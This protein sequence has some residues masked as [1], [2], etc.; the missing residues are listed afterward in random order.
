MSSEN[1][2]N[3]Y[4]LIDLNDNTRVVQPTMNELRAIAR[5]RGLRGYTTLCKDD[6][7]KFIINPGEVQPTINELRT[8]AKKRGLRGYTALSKDEL[9]QLINARQRLLD[10]PVPVIGTPILHPTEPSRNTVIETVHTIKNKFNEWANW[11]MEHIP[12]KPKVDEVLDSLKNKVNNI[13]NKFYKKKFELRESKTALKGNTKQYTIDGTEGID[14]VS[15]LNTIRPQVTNLLSSNRQI[16]VYF[17]LTC[18]MEKVDIKSGEVVTTEPYFSSKA[19]VNLDATDVGELYTNAVDQIMERMANFQMRGSNWKFRSVVK[20]DINT[21]VYKPLKGKSYIPLP[22]ELASKK[23][24][25]NMKNDD[26]QCFKWCVTR[27]LNPVGR[28]SENIT[29]ILRKQA[30]NLNWKGIEF[31]VAVSENVISRFEKNND[32]SLNVF[33]YEKDVYPLHISKQQRDKIVDLLLISD[34]KNKHYCWIKNFNRLMSRQTEKS[35]NSMHYCR[36]CLNGFSTDNALNKH[37]EYCSQHDA[38]K[39]YLPEPGTKL[40]FTN[41]NRLMRVPFIVYADFESF[42]KPI[43]TCQ[44]NSSESYTNKYQK[45]TPSSFCYYIKCFNDSV[46][47]PKLVSFTAESENDDVAKIFVNSLEEDIKQIY[48]QFKFKKKMI[49]TK[50]D[51]KSFNAATICHICEKDFSK[52]D[53][54]VRDHCHLS[55]KFRGAAHNS[56][57][58]SYQ[59]PK[60]FPIVFHNLSGYDSHLF[61]KKLR[62]NNEEKINCIPNSEEKY[63]S[64]SREVIVDKYKKD[65]EEKTVRRELRFIDSFRFMPSSLEALSEN[66]HK[67]QCK[68][69]AKHYSDKQ[70][71]LL[72]RKGVYPYN[73]VDSIDRLSETELPPKEAFYSKLNDSDISDEDYRHAQTVWN[74]FGCR[75][76]RDYHNIYNKSDVLLLADIFENFRDVCLNNY[77]LDPAWYYTSPGLAWDAAL[78]LTDVELE[79]L[80]DYDMILMIKHGI[81]GGISTISNRYA[82]ANNKYMG[83]AFDSSKPSSFITYHDTNSLY[84][85][86]MSK[87]LPTHGFK[88]IDTVELD[89]WKNHSCILEVDLEYSVD[90]HDLHN[91]YPL[92]PESLKLEGSVV[93]KLIPNLKDKKKYIIHCENLQ[94]YESLGLKITKIHRG[95]TFEESAWLKKYI[96]LNTEL[97]TKATNDFEKD[98]FKLMSNSVFGKTMENIENRVDV[99]LVCHENEAIKLTAKPNYDRHTIFDENLIAVHMKRT[100]L[101]YNKP[102]YLGMCILDLSK[103]LMYD[104]HYNYIKKKYGDDAMLLFTDT[105]S[106]AY[107]IKTENFYKDINNDIESRFDTSGYPENHPSGIK[108]GINKKVIGMFKDEAGGK[109]I[110]EFVGL[111][112]KLYSY[113][114]F[115]GDEHKKCKGIK[116]NVVKKSITHEDYKD[117][118]FT[119]REHLRRMNVIRSHHHDIFTEEINKVALSA[120]D[121]KRVIMDDGIRTLAYGHYCMRS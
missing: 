83:E 2:M 39:I 120:D 115:E 116:K 68:N 104:F 15:F 11:L 46:Y 76:L 32:I 82:K 106:L 66:L 29:K 31:P 53:E 55:G 99:R 103:T 30:E 75:S 86:A 71:D 100:K 81:R 8:I 59:V 35:H 61:I 27:A 21:V 91:D 64:F 12:E 102:I 96:D 41:Y 121:D 13:F 98:F 74:K 45:H 49:F 62:G 56:C 110:E 26:D 90:L 23:A 3:V 94:L 85:W 1:K 17:V 84:A 69:L 60:F 95:I 114:M 16:K 47:P 7:I 118:L 113:K 92:A 42:I 58:I 37:L 77:K 87:P 20:L 109:Q 38:Q 51:E 25:I 107:E 6:L 34:G 54:K 72:R 117:C 40:K 19:E 14:A 88:W 108:T 5:E 57:N 18:I 63:I 93:N 50:D 4:N 73:Y 111:R 67:D 9:S 119:K 112:A 36:R 80:S 48:M 33:G 89:N 65:G 10:K 44:P 101:V 52:E 24:I 28:D 70:F 105:D 43:D 78:K 22:K 97:R 79:L